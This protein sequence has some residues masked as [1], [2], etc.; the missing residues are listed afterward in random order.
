MA[1]DFSPLVIR[2]LIKSNKINS[3]INYMDGETLSLLD[4]QFRQ[5]GWP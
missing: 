5:T 2:G 3:I 4:W 1:D